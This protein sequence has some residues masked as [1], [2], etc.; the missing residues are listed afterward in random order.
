VHYPE[1]G[2][3]SVWLKGNS[4]AAQPIRSTTKICVVHVSSMEFL[5]SLL[6]RRFGR[7]QVATLQNVG[8]FLKLTSGGTHGIFSDYTCQC[9]FVPHNQSECEGL[10]Q[11]V[12]LLRS[13]TPND[14]LFLTKYESVE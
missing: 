6:R 12:T 8:C 10:E 2:S 14:S 5:H 13:L 4:L 1:L 11:G 3:A 7:A 9:S